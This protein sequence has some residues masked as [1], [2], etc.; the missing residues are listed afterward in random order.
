MTFI[1]SQKKIAIDAGVK[2]SR[3][4]DCVNKSFNFLSLLVV[5]AA[6]TIHVEKV[7]ADAIVM[8]VGV[9]LI[10]VSIPIIALIGIV[11]LAVIVI[12]ATMSVSF[13]IT[14]VIMP[15]T[16][17]SCG[18]T[19]STQIAPFVNRVVYDG[20]CIDV[21]TRRGC[22]N[23]TMIMTMTVMMAMAM[24]ATLTAATI[25]MILITVFIIRCFVEGAGAVVQ[26]S[27]TFDIS[28]GIGYDRIVFIGWT[29]I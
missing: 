5:G 22:I 19:D 7:F 17:C 10:I 23:M 18:R 3:F 16:V 15:H 21:D 13:A 2:L 27:D 29:V 1:I 8:R 26:C 11:A 6:V 14:I 9:L 28:G 20:V 24:A 4:G 12:I 25:I